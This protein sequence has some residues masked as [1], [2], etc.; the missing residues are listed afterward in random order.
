MNKV[1]YIVKSKL[2]FYP[3]CVTQ[4]R[5]LKELGVDVDVLFGSCSET[6]TKILK[7]E[8][9]PFKELC[10]KRGVFKGCLD[11]LNNYYCFRKSLNNELKKRNLDNTILWFG[12]AEALLSMK[13]S[14]FL[15]K[16]KYAITFLELLDD[17][18]FRMKL[19]KP[20]ALNAKFNL[21]C[22]ETRAYIMKF[23]WGLD[24]LP[25]VMPNKPYD[26]PEFFLDLTDKDAISLLNK[27]G[28]KK[29]ILYQGIIKEYGV[30]QNFAEAM[31]KLSEEFVLLL[32][33]PDPKNIFAKLKNITAKVIY[34]PYITAPNHLQVSSRAFAG[35]V[36]YNG[37]STLNR[38]FCAPNKIYEYAAFGMPMIANLIPGLTKTVGACGAAVCSK[39]TVEEIVFSVKIIDKNYEK[40]K[41]AS[42]DFFEATDIKRIMSEI[43]KKQLM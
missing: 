7:K 4:I 28:N 41:K 34:S 37:N 19:L 11:K 43:I 33:G 21:S 39:L 31:E 16:D 25:Y 5:T 40:M 24:T 26:N 8:S 6:V 27:I 15:K 9:I 23:L 35:I 10:D 13:G 12:N 42:K 18:P 32:M 3:P 2:H 38:A 14:P 29:I 17:N 30:L 1:I 36:F 20:L 22:E